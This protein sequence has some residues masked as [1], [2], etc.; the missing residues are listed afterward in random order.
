MACFQCKATLPSDGDYVNCG[1][2][3]NCFHYDCS[4]MK[5]STWRSKSEKLK[6][7]WACVNCR[8]K[9]P[10]TQ[11]LEDEQE[12]DDPTY[13]ALKRFLEAMFKK[14]ERIILERVDNITTLLNQV[15]DRFLQMADNIK[16]LESKTNTMKN[17]IEDLKLTLEMERQYGRS[18]NFVITGIPHSDKEDVGNKVCELL[19]LLDINLKKEEITSHRLPSS[20]KPSPIIVQC[21]TR[22]IRDNIVRKARKC[23][24]KLSLISDSQPDKPIF[25]NDH[26]TPYFSD[27]M[28][29]AN[30]SRKNKGYKFIWLNGNKIMVRKD[31]LTKAIQIVKIEDL[32][33]IV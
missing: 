1:K 6:N 27:L 17:D 18:K 30:L 23:R 12:P 21:L 13:M 26:L 20:K 19:A 8:I 7:E 2:C 5:K 33:K 25:F 24:P 9:K 22:E 31:N 14:Q 4:G 32:S 29:R 3:N 11:S 16:D 15:E 10:R 28:A